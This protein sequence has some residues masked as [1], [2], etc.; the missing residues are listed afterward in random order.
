MSETV[1]SKS[2]SILTQNG[3]TTPTRRVP[4]RNSDK[5]SIRILPSPRRSLVRTSQKNL[6]MCTSPPKWKLTT[7]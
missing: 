4:R 5:A 6:K 7:N 3:W 1:P 2:N